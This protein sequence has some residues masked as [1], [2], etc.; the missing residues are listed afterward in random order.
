MFCRK[1]AKNCTKPLFCNYGYKRAKS[2]KKG[3]RHVVFEIYGNH[4][5][6][7]NP[8]LKL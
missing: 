3:K 1:H 6:E 2:K 5:N 7:V 4:S 8:P